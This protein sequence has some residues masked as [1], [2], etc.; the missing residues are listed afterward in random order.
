MQSNAYNIHIM[1]FI[2]FIEYKLEYTKTVD[3]PALLYISI[4]LFSTLIFIN[5][6]I[7]I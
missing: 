1:K 5:S 3:I 6:N 2:P 4:Y 7:G